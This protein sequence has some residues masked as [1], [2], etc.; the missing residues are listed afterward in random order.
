[1]AFYYGWL[2]NIRCLCSEVIVH[3]SRE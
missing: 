1:M 2:R 3:P